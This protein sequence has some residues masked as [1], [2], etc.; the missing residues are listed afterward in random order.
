MSRR[1]A[2]AAA[3]VAAVTQHRNVSRAAARPSGAMLVM[4][5]KENPRWVRPWSAA[6]GRKRHRRG[7]SACAA[8]SMARLTSSAVTIAAA[9][10]RN[11]APRATLGVALGALFRSQAAAIV[12]ALLVNLAIDPAAQALA[13][14]LWRFLPTAADQ[15][16][17]QRGFSFV[18]ITS[19]A[20]LGRAAALLTFLCWV[21]AATAAAAAALRRDIPH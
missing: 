9:W 1:S 5:T 11:R 10:L 19:M 2:A 21:T 13:P 17:T 4:L 8:G 15:G 12:T 18:S 3:A 14:R 16:L 20:P 7:A 6:V